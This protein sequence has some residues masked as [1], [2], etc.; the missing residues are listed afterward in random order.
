MVTKV[1]DFVKWYCQNHIAPL[2][3]THRNSV[4]FS[5]LLNTYVYV[6][7]KN[8]AYAKKQFAEPI[9]SDVSAEI[10]VLGK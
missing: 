5:P 3:I 9:L 7:Y 8:T 10:Y 1:D 6:F 2:T 4:T